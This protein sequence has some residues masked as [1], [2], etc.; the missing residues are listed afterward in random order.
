MAGRTD[1][2]PE[3]GRSTRL[4]KPRPAHLSGIPQDDRCR[5]RAVMQR[6]STVVMRGVLVMSDTWGHAGS[7]ASQTADA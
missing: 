3:P 4:L 1:E 7:T 5:S 2:L 6:R